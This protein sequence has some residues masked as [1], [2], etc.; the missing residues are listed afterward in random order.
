M[1]TLCGDDII[2]A[3]FSIDQECKMSLRE[4]VGELLGEEV[5][6]SHQENRFVSLELFSRDEL[7]DEL[8]FLLGI[9]E[10]WGRAKQ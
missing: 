10:G 4:E 8:F 5:A 1:R 2:E 9:C 7:K 6:T 3:I